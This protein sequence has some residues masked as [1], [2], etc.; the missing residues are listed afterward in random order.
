MILSVCIALFITN[1][2]QSDLLSC[3]PRAAETQALLGSS[4]RTPTTPLT[5][6]EKG[7]FGPRK[8]RLWVLRPLQT[9]KDVGLMVLP[10]TS[11]C[12]KVLSVYLA[13]WDDRTN[14]DL[15]QVWTR[16]SREKQR[17][18]PQARPIPCCSARTHAP[19]E[20]HRLCSPQLPGLS[21]HPWSSHKN[22]WKCVSPAL[23]AG[24][25]S[26]SKAWGYFCNLC[27]KNC[28]THQY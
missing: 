13:W 23:P 16:G 27:S 18:Q 1:G 19:L 8:S 11:T 20:E 6:R 3:P 24:R 10:K 7:E 28:L 9:S 26:H 5:G 2:S 4:S 21:H 12:K 14:S 17:L 22:T 15:G 25:R